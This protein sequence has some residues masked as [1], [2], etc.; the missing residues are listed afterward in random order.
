[1]LNGNM[2]ESTKMTIHLNAIVA[3]VYLEQYVGVMSTQWLKSKSQ[4]KRMVNLNV[5]DINETHS[6]I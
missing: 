1:M 3:M 6:H 4:T 2:P 5:E